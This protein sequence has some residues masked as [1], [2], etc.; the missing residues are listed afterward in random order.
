[1]QPRQHV[2]AEAAQE[3]LLIV[4]GPVEDQMLEAELDVRGDPINDLVRVSGDDEPGRRA[5]KDLVGRRLHLGRVI[6]P[7]LLL[8]GERERRPERARRLG[9]IDDRGH[10]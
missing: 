8:G 1:M 4:T 7:R 5:V 9:V 2:G 10:S 6:D 3:A